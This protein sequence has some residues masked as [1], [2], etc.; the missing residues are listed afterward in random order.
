MSRLPP[1]PP[2]FRVIALLSL[3]PLSLCCFVFFVL[4]FLFSGFSRVIALAEL[5]CSRRAGGRVG[6]KW[7]L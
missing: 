7:K 6:A 4:Y 2:S 1:P 5:G 3:A